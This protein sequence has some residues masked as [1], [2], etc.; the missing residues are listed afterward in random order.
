MVEL[1]YLFPYSRHWSETIK[2]S[3][4]HKWRKSILPVS[5]SPL[6]FFFFFAIAHSS[7]Q[8]LEVFFRQGVMVLD[9]L[10]SDIDVPATLRTIK[11]KLKP[12]PD[13]LDEN[14]FLIIT[15]AY[16]HH[17]FGSRV[18]YGVDAKLQ[19]KDYT[20][21]FVYY[22]TELAE[23][24]EHWVENRLEQ[25]G[26]DPEFTGATEVLAKFTQRVQFALTTDVFNT[27]HLGLQ[28]P[29]STPLLC[30]AFVVDMA[31]SLEK[32]EVAL[33]EVFRML[34]PFYHA[35][36]LDSKKST[37]CKDQPTMLLHQW[38]SRHEPEGNTPTYVVNKVSYNSVRRTN[39]ILTC[40][41][42]SYPSFSAIEPLPCRK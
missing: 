36:I 38:V 16:A 37:E 8:Y 7:L 42:R 9:F 22:R 18:D 17:C 5:I 41:S 3:L 39:S 25:V 23:G 13:L 12:I 34:E 19:E 11:A 10:T 14:F 24:L 31:S 2:I 40:T 26:E 32:Y 28:L 27:A 1:V 4:F 21:A 6:K 35:V 15:K 30:R 29:T 33:M 20:K